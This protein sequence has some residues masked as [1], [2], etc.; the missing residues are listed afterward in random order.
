M[1]FSHQNFIFFTLLISCLS[2]TNAA[3][4]KVNIIGVTTD[5][6]PVGCSLYNSENG[7]PMD[8]SKGIQHWVAPDSTKVM[9]EYKDLTAGK[10][11]VSVMQD[12]NSNK[13][14]DTNILG[15]PKEPWGVSNNVRPSF[16]PPKFIEAAFTIQ[17]DGVNNI[18]VEI[19]K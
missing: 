6:G 5:N 3:D 4:L 14:V 7:F 15:I 17:D 9:C 8:G 1:K 19:A 11:A 12:N 10:Y 18:Q 16:R 2:A 13:K